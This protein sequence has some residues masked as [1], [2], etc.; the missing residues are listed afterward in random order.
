MCPQKWNI[1][2]HWGGGKEGHN[3]VLFGGKLKCQNEGKRHFNIL[4]VF[5]FGPNGQKLGKHRK[6]MPTALERCVWGMGDGSTLA[7]IPTEIG[8][9]GAAICWENYMPLL[10]MA[11]YGK[12]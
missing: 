2:G 7:V 5:F 4:K 8:R 12:G 1:F 6:V 11:Y 3:F 9:I 10:R